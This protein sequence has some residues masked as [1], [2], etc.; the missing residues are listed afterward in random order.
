MAVFRTRDIKHSRMR[1]PGDASVSTLDHWYF[2]LVKRSAR[3]QSAIQNASEIV[4]PLCW[5]MKAAAPFCVAGCGFI[6]FVLLSAKPIP[7][8]PSYLRPI[9]ASIIGALAVAILLALPG[10]AV[11]DPS[12]IKQRYW[13]RK[14]K[15]V[16]WSDFAS[17]IHDR[18]DG[19][20][21]VYGNLK[22][23]SFFRPTL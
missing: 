23:Q 13:W 7:E 1:D 10:R 4:F 11:I 2:S 19:S 14:D 22:L 21:I 18:N 12:G 15:Q 6:G 5:Q 20:T 9:V 8:D 3:S 16:P 17:V